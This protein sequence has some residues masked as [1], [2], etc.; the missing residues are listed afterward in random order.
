MIML[1]ITLLANESGGSF[2]DEGL[3]IFGAGG[4]YLFVGSYPVVY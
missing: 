3:R 2:F 1:S 4:K